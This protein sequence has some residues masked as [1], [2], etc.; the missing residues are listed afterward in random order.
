MSIKVSTLNNLISIFESIADRHEQINYFFRGQDYDINPLDISQFAMLTVKP[1]SA[2]MPKTDNG[3]SSLSVVFTVKC[4]DLVSKGIT[5]QPDVESDTLSILR[6][7]VI[8]FNQHPL[9]MDSDFNIVGDVSLEPLTGVF[10]QALTG[11]ETTITIEAPN[12]SS[13]CSNPVTLLT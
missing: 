1:E 10:D 4:I 12:K 6:D 9:Y 5:N 2:V 7:V 8:E 11:W 13:Y 3:Y